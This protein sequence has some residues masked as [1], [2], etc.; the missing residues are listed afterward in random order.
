MMLELKQRLARIDR[1]FLATVVAPTLLAAVYFL[2]MAS[3]VYT[4]ESRFVVRSPERQAGSPLGLLLRG[5]SF[6][7][8]QDDSFTVQEY[9]LS[10][11][12]LRVLVDRLHIDKSYGAPS[13]DR[14]SR[15]AGIDPD[16]SF[17]ALHRYFQKMVH[18]TTDSSSSIS[19]FTVRAFSARDAQAINEVLLAESEALVNR[20]NERGRMDMIRYAQAEVA[21]AQARARDTMLAVSVYRNKQAV[22]DP[23]KQAGIQLQQVAKMQDELIATKTQL[24]QLK[25]F[26][27]GNPQIPQLQARS[28]TLQDAITSETGKVAGGQRSLANKAADFQHFALE[29]EFAGKQLAS[30]L[31]SLENA[32]NEAQ[33]QQVYLERIAQPSLAD[34]AQEP[35]RLQ[36]ILATLI[37]GLAAWGILRMLV[38]GIREHQD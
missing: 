15:F 10:R 30:A 14:V 32:R 36:G 25:A 35:R 17:E 11:D 3:D 21:E 24:A 1:L 2:A 23:E 19:T 22:V 9:I 31:A 38:A 26:T 4:S 6:S 34:V 5:A 16:N 27:P 18:V 12:A 37:F 29:A 8:A 20:L 13:V 33:R 28:H 7:R